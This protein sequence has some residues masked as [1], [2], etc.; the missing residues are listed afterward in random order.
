MTPNLQALVAS[1]ARK[2]TQQG[3]SADGDIEIEFE[4][5]LEGEA[6]CVLTEG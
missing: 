1:D 4:F 5:E 6:F 3:C 2:L